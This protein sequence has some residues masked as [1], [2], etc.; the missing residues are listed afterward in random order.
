MTRVLGK[1]MYP[2]ASEECV[3]SR[4]GEEDCK[5]LFFQDRGSLG[6]STFVPL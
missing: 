6:P 4:E 3:L 2:D 1:K 5:H